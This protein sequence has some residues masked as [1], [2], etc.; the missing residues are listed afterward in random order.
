MTVYQLPT[1]EIRGRKF[2]G[3]ILQGE[4]TYGIHADRDDPEASMDRVVVGNAAN[5]NWF[6]TSVSS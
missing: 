2:E 5:A 3:S 1:F 6:T 4:T